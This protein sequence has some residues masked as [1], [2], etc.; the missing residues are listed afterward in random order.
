MENE[1]VHLRHVMLYEFRKGVSVGTAQ[2]NI[3]SVYLD[4]APALRTVKKWFGR[5]RNSDFNLEDQLCSGR[6][7]GIDDDI[8]C[9]LVE[10][11]S[12]ITTE[13]IVERLKIDNSTAFRHLKKFGY[14]SKLD[15]WVPHL[16]TERNKLNRMNVAIS[17]L[18]RNKKEPFLDRMIT[19]D[20]KWILYNNVQRKRT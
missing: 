10:E 6:P 16:L 12:R 11:N 14:V 5:F 13:E 7:S 19:G 17:L 9:A 15:T 20:E 2:T 8:V 4:R 18:A 3:Q 1:K